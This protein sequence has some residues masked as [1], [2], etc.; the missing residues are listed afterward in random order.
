MCGW[1]LRDA[2]CQQ[3]TYGVQHFSDA[4]L[5][6]MGRRERPDPLR[7]VLD[8]TLS[9]G[10]EAFID[11]IIGHPGESH[12]DFEVTLQVVRELMRGYP[13]VRINLNPFN[14]IEG[15]EV[16]LRPEAHGVTLRRV[17]AELP[18]RFGHLQ[19]LV[20]RFVRR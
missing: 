14:L 19:E 10:I 4:M 6:R 13:N 9:L 18:E 7:R 5:T 15:S 11:V 1:I 3:I 8:D 17:E 2:G 20:G 16:M 12:E